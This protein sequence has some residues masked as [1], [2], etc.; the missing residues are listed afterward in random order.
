MHNKFIKAF[1]KEIISKR[2]NKPIEIE[3]LSIESQYDEPGFH[4][5][6]PCIKKVCQKL[7]ILFLMIF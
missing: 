3:D 4:W 2:I 6:N 7:L 5:S 1:F